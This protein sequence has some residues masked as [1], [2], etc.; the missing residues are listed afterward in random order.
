[1][2]KVFFILLG[3]IMLASCVKSDKCKCKITVGDMTLE[4]QIIARPDDTTCGKIKV[5][6]I[7]GEIVGIQLTKLAAIK[8]VNYNE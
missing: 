4:N 2:K 5:E 1:M 3:S 6:D 8:C 7:Q